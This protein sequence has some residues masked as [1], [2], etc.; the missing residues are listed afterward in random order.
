[1]LAE[2]GID[3]ARLVFV[4][5]LPENVQGAENVGIRS[6]VFSEPVAGSLARLEELICRPSS[7]AP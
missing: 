2:L 6:L 1:V 3:R 5:D 4:D 7:S